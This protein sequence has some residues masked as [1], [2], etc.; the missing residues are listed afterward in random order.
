MSKILSSQSKKTTYLLLVCVAGLWGLIFYRVFQV[1]EVPDE[2]VFEKPPQKAHYFKAVDH[3][4]DT[5]KLRFD[6]RDPFK[7]ALP[8][9]AEGNL[10]KQPV[11][12]LPSI[13]AQKPKVNWA[14]VRYNGFIENKKTGQKLAIMIINGSE[15][16]LAEGQTV[17]G[18]KLIKHYPDSVKLNYQYETKYIRLK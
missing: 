13:V 1:A 16:M 5:T 17:K 7:V 6:Y 11:N 2:R 9:F 10:N 18:F 15:Q 4:N 12:A 8:N 14:D 3:S